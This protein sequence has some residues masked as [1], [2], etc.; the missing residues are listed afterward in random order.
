M[1]NVELHRGKNVIA[2]VNILR[3]QSFTGSQWKQLE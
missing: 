2:L 1:E 3:P